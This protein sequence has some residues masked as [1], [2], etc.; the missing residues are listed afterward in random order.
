[1]SKAEYRRHELDAM[2]TQLE[3]ALTGDAGV[4]WLT[5]VAETVLDELRHLRAHE[6]EDE[7]APQPPAWASPTACD[8][9]EFHAR[10]RLPRR[11]TPNA[12]AVP[13]PLAMLRLRLLREEVNELVKGVNRLDVTGIADALA[14]VVYVSYGTALTYGIDLDRVLAE[15]HRSNLTKEPPAEPGGKA[16]KGPAYTPPD[17]AG[18]LMRQLPLPLAPDEGDGA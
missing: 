13:G 2:I 4:T 10:Y 16:R 15:V 7:N 6:N 11:A 5:N 3:A 1:M 9:D 17:V 8:V 18:V 14:D 12:H